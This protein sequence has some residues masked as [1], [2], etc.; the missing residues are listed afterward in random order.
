ML[1]CKKMPD[2]IKEPFRTEAVLNR[3]LGYSITNAVADDE[4]RDYCAFSFDMNGRKILFRSA[5][6]TPKK[7][8][9]F[10]TLWK[11]EGSSPIMPINSKDAVDFVVI[12][13][14]AGSD[15]GLFVFPKPVLVAKGVFK[16]ELKA[17]KRAMRVYPEWDDTSN[18]QAKSTQLWQL[19]YFINLTDGVGTDINRLKMLFDLGL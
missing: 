17:G 8:G 1:S 14:C 9:Q 15:Y 5:K 13:V 12:S 18:R 2:I 16:S 3:F 10:V 4:S 11:R 6:I 7:S 19:Q